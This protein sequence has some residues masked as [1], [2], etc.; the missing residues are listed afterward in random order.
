MTPPPFFFFNLILCAVDGL[1]CQLALDGM[2]KEVD[3]AADDRK[4]G[5]GSLAKML[6]SGGCC[7][8]SGCAWA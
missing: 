3:E 5:A 6:L 7:S 4:G 2:N 1:W 8:C